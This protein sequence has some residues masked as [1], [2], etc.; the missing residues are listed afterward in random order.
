MI[1]TFS[2]TLLFPLEFAVLSGVIFSLA[3]YLYQ[4]SVPRV[5]PVVPDATFRHFIEVPGAP[6]CCEM[7]VMNIRGALFFGATQHIEETLLESLKK[8]PERRYLLLRLH[9]V[10]QCDYTGIEMLEGVVRT[11]R[12]CGGD[13]YLVQARPAVREIMRQSG[14]EDFLGIDHFLAQEEAIDHLFEGVIDSAVCWYRCPNRV[15]AEC[16]GL[17]K[18]FGTA[19]EVHPCRATTPIDPSHFL[20]VRQ[21]EEIIET[22]DPLILDV[23]EPGEYRRGHIPGA[24]SFPLRRVLSEPGTLPLGRPLLLIC[25]AG[26]RSTRAMRILLDLGFE[27]LQN[28]KGGI[29]SWKAANMPLEVE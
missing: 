7:A 18:E 24:V 22:K 19:A 29:L 1:A 27:D 16:Q 17:P 12:E 13:V 15:F 10:D 26:R 23:R 14:F 9:G 11:F 28:L 4:S 6:E 5:V 8:Y 21:V 20:N 2:A 3:M 25:R